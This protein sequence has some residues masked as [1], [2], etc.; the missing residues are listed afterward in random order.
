MGTEK[1]ALIRDRGYKTFFML[2]YAEH[3][4]L[5]ARRYKNIKKVSIV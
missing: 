2:N 4:I 3:E 5:N 1:K